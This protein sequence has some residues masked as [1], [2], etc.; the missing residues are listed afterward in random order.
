MTT[1]TAV[2]A[3]LR[4]VLA[5]I[6]AAEIHASGLERAYLTGAAVAL[7]AIGEEFSSGANANGTISSAP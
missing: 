2:A 7:D 6:D 1:A 4:A 5:A 3:S